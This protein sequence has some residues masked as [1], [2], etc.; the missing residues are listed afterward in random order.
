MTTDNTDHHLTK[1]KEAHLRWASNIVGHKIPEHA[2]KYL[3]IITLW[4]GGQ[5]LCQRNTIQQSE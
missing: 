4:A 5:Q 3:Y 1:E 2:A